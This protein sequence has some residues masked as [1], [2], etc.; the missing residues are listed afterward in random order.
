MTGVEQLELTGPGYQL[1]VGTVCRGRVDTLDC[2]GNS[3]PGSTIH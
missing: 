3:V 1:D 2:L